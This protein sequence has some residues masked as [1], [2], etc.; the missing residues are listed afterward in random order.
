MFKIKRRTILISMGMV[1]ILL[2]SLQKSMPVSSDITSKKL[3]KHII[4]DAGH[5]FPDGGAVGI[6]GTIESTIN[7]KIAKKTAEIL[8]KAGY[9]VTLTR[10]NENALTDEG[11]T[12]SQ[13]KKNDMYKRLDMIN[14]SDSDIFISIHMNKFTDSRNRGA[15]V[16][17]SPKFPEAA[18]LANKIQKELCEIPENIKKRTALK[19]SDRIFLLS[20][21]NIP[22]VIVE[23]GFLSNYEEEKRLNSEK[24]QAKL[25][26]AIADGVK[27]YYKSLKNQSLTYRSP[28]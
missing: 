17:Y 14:K 22:A 4:I 11:Q 16:L 20:N 7:I 24:Y 9:T 28:M 18:L 3:T 26:A 6:S 8:T 19:G 5:G 25:A 23:C 12:L 1:I 13:K 15:Q 27:S 2:S 10:K 21:S